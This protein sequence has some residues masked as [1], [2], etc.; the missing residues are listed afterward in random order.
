MPLNLTQEAH[1]IINAA[2]NE[3]VWKRAMETTGEKG[4]PMTFDLLKLAL[5]EV[6]KTLFRT[7]H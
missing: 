6:A 1:E 5:P 7:D 2:R 3:S 4:L